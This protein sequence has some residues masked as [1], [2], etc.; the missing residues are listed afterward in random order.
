MR[1]TTSKEEWREAHR[2]GLTW[3]EYRAIKQ[4]KEDAI[5]A[6]NRLN[7]YKFKFSLFGSMTGKW[8]VYE[9]WNHDL[10]L[11]YRLSG[12][13][14]ERDSGEYIEI[15]TDSRIAWD[16]KRSWGATLDQALAVMSRCVVDMAAHE[17][18]EQLIGPDGKRLN[19]PHNNA[20]R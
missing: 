17:F 3:V 15:T 1:A 8:T 19:N 9:D 16:V 18:H 20:Y 6:A 12:R 5:V 14:R 10:Y 13:V 7:E 4:C 2:L 11:Q